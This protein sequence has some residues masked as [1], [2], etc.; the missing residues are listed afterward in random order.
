M[1]APKLIEIGVTAS[2]PVVVVAVPER[3]TEIDGSDAS[4]VT[5]RVAVAV[6]TEFGVKV[7]EK[8]ALA[9][10]TKG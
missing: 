2:V 8:L 10:A 5:A 9:P 6:P 1:I 7:T 4:E 3:A